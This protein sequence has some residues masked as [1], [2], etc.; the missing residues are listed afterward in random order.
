MPARIAWGERRFDFTFPVDFYPELIERLRGTPA[1]L[2][3]RLRSQPPDR[4]EQSD[5]RTQPRVC[6]HKQVSVFVPGHR[7]RDRSRW[8]LESAKARGGDEP[9]LTLDKFVEPASGAV[10]VPHAHRLSHKSEGMAR[11][12]R[13]SGGVP[14]R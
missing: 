10:N 6:R 4:G 1:R 8:V 2:A 7:H 9:V 3:D 14:G 12:H 13:H 11:V 5:G